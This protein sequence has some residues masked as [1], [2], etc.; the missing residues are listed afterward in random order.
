MMR[1]VLVLGAVR[2]PIGS[3]GGIFSGVS[4]VHLGVTATKE[5]L[6]RA[7][8]PAGKMEEA[9][10]GCVLTA[11]LGQN[12]ARQIALGAGLPEE[13]PAFTVNKV[14]GSGMKALELGWQSLQLGRADCVLAGGAENMTRA[15]SLL[16]SLR[17]GARLGNVEAVDGMIHDGLWEIF[18]QYHM[19]ITAENIAARYG[20]TREEQD[21]FAFE[22]QRKCAEATAAGHF[23]AEIV[24]VAIPDKKGERIIDRDEH[25]KP[26]TDLDKMARLRPAFKQDGSV[27]A[28]NASGINDGAAAV[29]LA[30]EDT[31][32]EN[33]SREN[34]VYLR[35]IR[36]SGCDPKVMGLGPIGA[37]RRLLDKNGL[38]ISDIDLWE[39]NEAFAAQAIAVQRELGM[40]AEG[41]NISGGAIALGHPIGCTGAR[42]TATLIHGMKRRA[43]HYGVAAMCIGGG[44]GIAGLFE[45]CD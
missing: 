27:T 2:T 30:A 5:A 10:F 22:S 23:S 40:D 28:A 25:P 1:N 38:S 36:S 21:A 4:A 8:I 17:G 45:N 42:V 29:V 44:Q 18:N 14:C 13:V 35:D 16:P 6:R 11:G 19:G 24:P 15:P 43:A 32:P 34:A 20:I 41:V 31:L 9:I 26:D 37:V 39:M 33:A 7:A 12:P 3:M